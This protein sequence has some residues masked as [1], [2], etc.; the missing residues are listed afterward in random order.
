MKSPMQNKH[1]YLEGYF[2]NSLQGQKEELIELD[3]TLLAA[4][5]TAEHRRPGQH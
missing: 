2:P 1:M 5:G 3:F 4:A